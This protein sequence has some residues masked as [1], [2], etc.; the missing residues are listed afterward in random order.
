MVQGE[1]VDGGGLYLEGTE[2]TGMSDGAVVD[3]AGN[4][5]V[6]GGDIAWGK[7]ERE[8]KRKRDGLTR[9]RGVSRKDWTGGQNHERGHERQIR[10]VQTG[11]RHRDM[12]EAKA[13][14]DP[15]PG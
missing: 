9:R 11:R 15:W 10:C 7:S 6:L 13:H 8:K 2:K 4:E 3:H 1:V 12:D 5:G 14:G